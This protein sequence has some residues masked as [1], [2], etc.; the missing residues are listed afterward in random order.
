MPPPRP[1]VAERPRAPRSIALKT[2]AAVWCLAGLAA[3]A[4]AGWV[5]VGPGQ[6]FVIAARGDRSADTSGIEKMLTRL[7]R[8][9]RTVHDKLSSSE[10]QTHSLLGRLASLEEKSALLTSAAQPAMPSPAT[11]TGSVPGPEQAGAPR[12]DPAPRA[13]NIT[14]GSILQRAA[15]SDTAPAPSGAGDA[16]SAG[17]P[18]A[19]HAIQL[20]TAANLDA[21]RLNWSL[22]SDRHRQ[23]L[24]ALQI[25]YRQTSGRPNAPY[26][27][28]AGPVR[29]V[30]DAGR[31]CKELAA[32]GIACRATNFSG[33]AL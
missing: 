29:S 12:P 27:L 26:Q 7:S 19:Q 15:A 4:Y 25:R 18:K 16:A 31:I 20:A 22:L 8:D 3:A 28:I 1:A 6:D 33:E 17:Q 21:L 13:S 24:G 2:H 11:A 23:L 30:A 32:T 5:L 14:T 10:Q 9:V